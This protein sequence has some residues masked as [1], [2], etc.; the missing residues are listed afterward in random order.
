MLQLYSIKTILSHA[1]YNRL[2]KGKVK[3]VLGRGQYYCVSLCEQFCTIQLTFIL[4][5]KDHSAKQRIELFQ[6]I[7]S[8]IELLMKDF[9]QASTKP[10]AYIPCY[11]KDC[12]KLHVELE[13]LYDVDGQHCP[14]KEEPLPD[15]YYKDLFPGPGIDNTI[16]YYIHIAT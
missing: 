1:V 7:Q 12:S 4:H 15:E 5:R 9:M 14:F 11:Y 16:A 3:M 13:L 2:R 10:K 6:Y 8:K